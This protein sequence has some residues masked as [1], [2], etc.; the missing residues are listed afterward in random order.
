MGFLAMVSRLAWFVGFTCLFS[1]VASQGLPYQVMLQDSPAYYLSW[2]ITPD[3][4]TIMMQ[5]ELE[6]WAW[7]GI[8]WKPLGDDG[9]TNMTGGDFIVSQFASNGAV[10]V[11]D[12]Y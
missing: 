11:V 12:H 9:M 4:K 2:G 8:G 6:T 3:N 10:S 7:V 1:L 5:I